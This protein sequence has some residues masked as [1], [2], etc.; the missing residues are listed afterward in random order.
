M[1]IINMAASATIHIG[2][3][4]NGEFGKL[5]YDITVDTDKPIDWENITDTMKKAY[6]VV[7]AE[8]DSGVKELIGATIVRAV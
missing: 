8:L 4:A 3:V 1:A 7:V 5:N 2:H 6:E